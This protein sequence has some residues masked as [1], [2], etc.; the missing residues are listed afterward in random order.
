M[1]RFRNTSCIAVAVVASACTNVFG[2]AFHGYTYDDCKDGRRCADER[3]PTH[4]EG[5]TSS[6]RN[7]DA[8]RAGVASSM[9]AGSGSHSGRLVHDASGDVDSDTSHVL[10][11]KKTDAPDAQR[12]PGGDGGGDA[13]RDA[14]VDAGRDGNA[15]YSGQ[16]SCRNVAPICGP[17]AND[18]C[19]ASD[20]VPGGTF[21]MG[22]D[23][24]PVPEDP[25]NAPTTDD[26][27]RHP[28]TV[29]TFVL[30]R[31]EV[32]LGRFR[33]FVDDFKT[34][35]RPFQDA[36]AIAGRPGS[37][38]SVLWTDKLPSYDYL[39]GQLA[40]NNYG[41]PIWTNSRGAKEA[42]AMNCLTW[43]VAYAF[44]LWDGGR[45]PTEAE[46]EYAAAG[47]DQQRVFPWGDEFDDSRGNWNMNMTDI[48]RVGEA[49]AGTGRARW[50]QYDLA[51]NVWEFTRDSLSS[52]QAASTP[53]V[54]P[55]VPYDGTPAGFGP[56]P[57][58]RGGSYFGGAE[59]NITSFHRA[60]WP[61]DEPNV[62]IGV[63]CAREAMPSSE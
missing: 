9:D 26:H 59:A 44:C 15:P 38:W 6:S 1:S 5:G 29:S 58:M 35:P 14:S 33:N 53:L 52:Y 23:T 2:D 42:Y 24:S 28:V 18:D 61:A 57:I 11:S 40:C 20:V 30:D 22:I 46:W 12:R 19:C 31:Y 45:L 7:A 39:K 17:T 63:R 50:G 34:W 54:D 27:P 10:G 25:V 56:E 16:P 41:K 4:R 51:G 32:T 47:G 13:S 49:G 55:V 62:S 60:Q 21:M 3:A 37:G 48:T 8:A 36:G 43:F